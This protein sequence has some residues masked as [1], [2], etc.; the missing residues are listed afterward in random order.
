MS[1]SFLSPVV[2]IRACV[3]LCC[4]FVHSEVQDFILS[5]V[6][7][8][9]VRHCDDRYNFTIKTIF[10]S[11]FYP[12]LFVGG[13][14]PYLCLSSYSI[15]NTYWIYQYHRGC[16]IRGRNYLPFVS[17][18]VHPWF[19][20]GSLLL[21]FLVFC[22]VLYPVILFWFVSLWPVS[23]V[24]NVASVSELSILDCPSSFL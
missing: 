1:S 22:I 11:S 19:L 13:I 18:W 6:F 2:C 23:C 3:L 16:I 9:L 4:L 8:F 17:I 10:G 21:I 12:Q 20:V 5:N 15:S 7:T 14:M 24:L